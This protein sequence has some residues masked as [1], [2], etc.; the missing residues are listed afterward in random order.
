[1]AGA[2]CDLVG[3]MAIDR[4][5]ATWRL[6]A[7]HG[8]VDAA[9]LLHV[10]GPVAEPLAVEDQQVLE[11]AV[12][13]PVRDMRDLGLFVET[14][15]RLPGPAFQKIVAIRVEQVSLA[16]RN[17]QC[18]MPSALVDHAEERQ[19]LCPSPETLVHRVGIAAL[20]VAQ[21]LE[22]PGDRV[23]VAVDRIGGKQVA[24]LG[25]QD[26]D[27]PHEHGQQTGV[28]VVRVFAEHVGQKLAL[29]LVVGR[30]ES[31]NQ[32]VKGR[33][34]LLGKLRRDDIL[35]LAAVG[36]NGGQP[37]LLG[38]REEPVGV[39]QHVQG[40]EDR[41]AGDLGHGR[42]GECHVTARLAT[43]GIDKAE[44]RAVAKQPDRHFRLAQ[45]PL[46]TGVGSW[47]ASA[48]RPWWQPHQSRP[49]WRWT[50]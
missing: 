28:D 35:V 5:S 32:F 20:I 49:P 13:N 3:L 47:L 19:Q 7:H 12:D 25:V 30:L 17:P 48:G 36:Q 50:E 21:P 16:G 23:E 6:K 11:H 33:Q 15:W 39:E 29:A 18:T 44:M 31:A 1:M 14:P 10:E 26:E 2:P 37:L 43:R 22:Q 41:P 40:G 27:Q 4:P 9:D 42:H 24:V 38:Q 8:F 45:E 34:D 46:E